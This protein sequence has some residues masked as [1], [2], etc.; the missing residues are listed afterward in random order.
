MIRTDGKDGLNIGSGP[1]A[2]SQV[3]VMRFF[4]SGT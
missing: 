4:G 3:L 1:L 2:K